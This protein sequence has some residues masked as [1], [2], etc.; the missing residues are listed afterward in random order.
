LAFNDTAIV[1]SGGGWWLPILADRQ[2]NLPPLNYSLEKGSSPDY[3]TW[4][5]SLV[6]AIQQ[7]GIDH[8]EILQELRDRQIDYIYIG[9]KQGQLNSPG[10][11]IKLETLLNNPVFQ[12]VYH[13]DRVWLFKIQHPQE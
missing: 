12:P 10:P 4:I 2:T 7:N 11:L 13:Q 3:R 1:G 5:N 6:S 8:P 9:Q